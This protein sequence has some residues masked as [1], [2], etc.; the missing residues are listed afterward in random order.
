VGRRNLPQIHHKLSEKL[1]LI[2]GFEKLLIAYYAKLCF[3][4]V[5]GC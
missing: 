2:V 4:E 1:T 3:Y 5:G